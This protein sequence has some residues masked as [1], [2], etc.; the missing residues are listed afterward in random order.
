MSARTS[1][2][3]L[4][5]SG[6]CI[7]LH[8]AVMIISDGA[9]TPLWLAVLL[10]FVAVASV[11]YVLHGRF[12][13]RQPLALSAF[14]RYAFAMSANIPLA[15]ITTWFWLDVAGLPMAVA[16]PIASAC[17]LALN[18]VLGRWAIAAPDPGLAETR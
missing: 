7:L 9:G 6:F 18:F 12:T 2:A 4:A 11:G 3:Y 16:A 1:V 5:V 14:G 15:F 17:M 13:F 8:N 10:S